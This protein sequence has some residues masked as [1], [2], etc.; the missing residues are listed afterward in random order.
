[1]GPGTV[2]TFRG[3]GRLLLR[4]ELLR[5]AVWTRG[6]SQAAFATA[7]VGTL[8]AMIIEMVAANHIDAPAIVVGWVIVGLGI[9]QF[10]SRRP[11]AEA[12][13]APA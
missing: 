3:R 1:M 5:F 2:Y 4:F 12:D 8:V 11:P 7:A 13:Y 6:P 10:G 9:A